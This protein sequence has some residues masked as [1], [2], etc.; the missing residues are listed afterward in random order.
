MRR[1]AL[2]LCGGR[3]TRMGRD[4]ATLP[5]GG[6]TLLER[7]V[8]RL[9]DVV[10]DVVVVARP[11]QELPALEG[12]VRLAR[13]EAPDR[14]PLMGLLAGL[15]T[16]EADAAFATA[17]DAPF[18]QPAV[19]DLLFDR[20]ARNGVDAVVVEAEG[21]LHPLTAVYR[22]GLADV[23]RELVAAQRMRPVYLFDEAP[24]AKVDEDTL[25]AVDPELLTLV[26][27]NTPEAYDDARQ[28]LEATTVRV[29]LYEMARRLAGRTEFH[30]AAK[31]LGEALDALRRRHRALEG[32]VLTADGLAGHWRASV[33]GR[34]FTTDVATPLSPGDRVVLVSALAGG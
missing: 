9:R 7:V 30:V 13:D 31:T 26:N 29:E 16:T 33:G 4:K 21:Y 34:T 3:S 6:E 28:R 18:L 12:D 24:T 11:G 20:L 25:R 23:A 2:V 14:G 19:M 8:W 15:E 10:D 27:C 1:G 17:V 32:P 22:K 5:F